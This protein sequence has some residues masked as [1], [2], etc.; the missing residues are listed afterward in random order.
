MWFLCCLLQFDA[1]R[2][3]SPDAAIESFIKQSVQEA[4]L[5]A[6]VFNGQPP[7][8]STQVGLLQHPCIGTGEDASGCCQAQWYGQISP[9]DLARQLS[10]VLLRGN[11]TKARAYVPTSSTAYAAVHTLSDLRLQHFLAWRVCPVSC[12]VPVLP[13]CHQWLA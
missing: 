11:D 4:G 7:K 3:A 1:R 8:M 9:F 2:R 6:K 13:C 10:P 12:L 5:L